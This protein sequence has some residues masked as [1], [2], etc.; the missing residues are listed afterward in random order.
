MKTTQP[1]LLAQKLEI[2]EHY[3]Y[4]KLAE[5]AKDPGNAGLLRQIAAQEL[6][7]ARFW[8]TKTGI[9]I[10][11]DR[12][13]IRKTTFLARLLGLTFVLKQME[14]REGTGSARYESLH[15]CSLRHA[16]WLWKKKLM[17]RDL[18]CRMRKTALRGFHCAGSERCSGGTD[19]RFGGIHAHPGRYPY[20]QCG[21][22]GD[23]ISAAFS[24]AASDYLCPG[25]GNTAA[26]KSALYTGI[27]YFFTVILLILPFLLIPANSRHWV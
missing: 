6:E 19:G 27:S 21:R 26:K 25:E 18:E 23:G 5:R 13:R 22:S 16:S 14:K 4:L 11:P 24:M 2:T 17:N 15:E 20:Y 8:E 9:R 3:I 12:W 10:K 1:A 7:H